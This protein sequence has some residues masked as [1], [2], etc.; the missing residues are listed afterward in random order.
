MTNTDELTTKLLKMKARVSDAK[1][2]KARAEGALTSA[3]QRLKTEFGCV[4]VAAAKKQQAKL[5]TEIDTLTTEYEN[6]IEQLE[7]DHEWDD[8]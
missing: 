7:K 8:V 1:E 5:E 4:T 3:M 6:G 2:E